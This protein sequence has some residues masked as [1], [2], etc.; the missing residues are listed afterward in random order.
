[1]DP[2]AR[3]VIWDYILEIKKSYNTTVLISTNYAE[4]AEYLCS[5][6]GIL[7]RGKLVLSGGKETLLKNKTLSQLFMEN[8]GEGI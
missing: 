3:K 6:I 2:R 8:T 4:E 1:L 7:D 5:H